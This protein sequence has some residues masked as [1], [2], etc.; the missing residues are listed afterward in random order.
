MHAEEGEP[1]ERTPESVSAAVPSG[2][3]GGGKGSDSPAVVHFAHRLAG[4]EQD[5]G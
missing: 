3:L 2:D 4:E 1:L 5:G